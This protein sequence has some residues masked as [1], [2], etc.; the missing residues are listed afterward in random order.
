[1][2]PVFIGT[3]IKKAVLAELDQVSDKRRSLVVVPND[4]RV[5]F[6]VALLECP[7]VGG[8]RSIVPNAHQRRIKDQVLVGVERVQGRNASGQK[9][10]Q[11]QCG[12]ANDFSHRTVV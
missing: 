6:L 10:G 3:Q 12:K 11:T 2:Q 9:N 7:T 5:A 8:I 4:E 1:I